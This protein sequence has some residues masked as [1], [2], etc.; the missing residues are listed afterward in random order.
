MQLIFSPETTMQDLLSPL[1]DDE[2]DRLDEFLLDRVPEDED[3]RGRDEGV[4]GISELDG[5][6]TAIV[7][8]PEAIQPSVWLN[9]V[10]GD[11][12]PEWENEQEFME[13]FGLIARHMNSISDALMEQPDQF[14]PIFMEGKSGR[15][16]SLIVD[17]WCD[18]YMRGVAL[19]PE[20][21]NV[22][23]LD[24]R[25]L[26]APIRAFTEQSGWAAHD[27]SEAETRNMQRAITPNVREIH[28]YWL[29]RRAPPHATP[30]T[31]RRA[32]PRVGRNDPCPCGSGKKYKKCC[33]H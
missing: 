13:I 20:Q 11:Y 19:A 1:T 29:A 12:P 31:V 21:W 4:L 8:G 5:M 26:L 30:A 18:G 15:E 27:R 22:G 7:S 25:I 23:G 6:L 14:E 16:K 10:W 24:M 2:L 28:A 33:L 3:T 17:E 32:G 9:A